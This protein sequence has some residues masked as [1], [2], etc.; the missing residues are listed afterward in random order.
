MGIDIELDWENKDGVQV[1][2]LSGRLDL[3]KSESFENAVVERIQAEPRNLV[4]NL[5]KVTYMSSSGIRALLASYRQLGA[6]DRRMCL[7]EVSPVVKK[8]MDVVE[9]GQVFSIYDQ[10]SEAIAAMAAD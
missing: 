7:C 5:S 3:S 10:E 1:V 2:R 6:V 8:V 9:I 4:I